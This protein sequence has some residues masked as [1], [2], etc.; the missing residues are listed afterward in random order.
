MISKEDLKR[1]HL[2]ENLPEEMLDKLVPLIEVVEFDEGHVIYTRGDLAETL[3]M[4]R[5]GKVLL[6]Q[7]ISSRA[8]VT[9]GTINPGEVLG[10]AALMNGHFYHAEAIC[11]EKCKFFAIRGQNMLTVFDQ[12]FELGYKMMKKVNLL[13]SEQLERR[14]EQLL[15]AFRTHPD[16]REIGDLIG[17][18]DLV[19]PNNA[20]NDPCGQHFE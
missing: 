11:S 7:R 12:H 19:G 3:F 13:L 8:T 14:T 10:L 15:R 17:E 20:S 6:E 5:R 1:I 18:P 2:L 4:L 9:V 16:M